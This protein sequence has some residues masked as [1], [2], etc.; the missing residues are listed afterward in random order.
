MKT[1][2]KNK[3]IKILKNSL[4][5]NK[6]N[7]NDQFLRISS[8]YYDE[9]KIAKPPI[10]IKTINSDSNDSHISNAH[11]KFLIDKGM[12]VYRYKNLHGNTEL[13]TYFD[14]IKNGRI[15]EK[16][17]VIYNKLYLQ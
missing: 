12:K 9:S 7:F 17:K 1:V 14:K 15:S 13:L 11:L 6:N 5:I 16:R 2:Q 3:L 4:A 10:Y 8:K